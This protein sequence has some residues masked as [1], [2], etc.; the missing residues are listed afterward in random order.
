[1]YAGRYQN[2]EPRPA[3]PLPFQHGLETQET[4]EGTADKR[5]KSRVESD[6]PRG[7]LALLWFF[8]GWHAERI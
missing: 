4:P 5:G 1:M 2:L 6:D 8:S 7:V 3:T